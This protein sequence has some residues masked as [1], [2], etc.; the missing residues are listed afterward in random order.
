M[1]ETV[2]DRSGKAFN[3]IKEIGAVINDFRINAIGGLKEPLSSATL[4]PDAFS[5]IR[6]RMSFNVRKD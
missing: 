2:N 4:S 6:T 5:E 1:K 3:T